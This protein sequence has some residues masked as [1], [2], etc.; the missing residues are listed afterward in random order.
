MEVKESLTIRGVGSTTSVAWR[1]GAAADKVFELWGDYNSN[2]E[3]DSGDYV[4]Y[5][6]QQGQSGSGLGAD[7]DDNG[8]VD[9]LDYSIYT[10]HFGNTLTLLNVL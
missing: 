5:R 7:G 8:V 4:T 10:S 6:K 3:V 9:S 1:P 2:Y